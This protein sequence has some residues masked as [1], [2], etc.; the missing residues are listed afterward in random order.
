MKNYFLLL[1]CLL[2][3][4]DT[5]SQI[6]SKLTFQNLY[7]DNDIKAIAVA[8]QAFSA[9]FNGLYENSG[10]DSSFFRLRGKDDSLMADNYIYVKL[11]HEEI[12]ATRFLGMEIIGDTA[13]R[14]YGDFRVKNYDLTDEQKKKNFITIMNEANTNEIVKVQTDPSGKSF[15]LKTFIKSSILI[16]DS[17]IVSI[18]VENHNNW[19]NTEKE[20]ND[21]LNKLR[22]KSKW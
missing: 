17:D 18:H 16:H 22:R 14:F 6:S 9:S 1:T 4:S 13:V 8:Y 21:K 2:W 15:Y 5:F 7:E 19:S 20:R 3:S 12:I 11:N 10:F